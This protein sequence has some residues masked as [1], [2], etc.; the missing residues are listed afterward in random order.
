MEAQQEREALRDDR[1][2]KIDALC[3]LLLPGWDR[4]QF[5]QMREKLENGVEVPDEELIALDLYYGA[6]HRVH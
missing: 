3:R 2:A 5:R 6:T 1:I 4:R